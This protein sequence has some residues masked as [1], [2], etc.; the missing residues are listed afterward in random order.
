LETYEW[1]T[2]SEVYLQTSGL[3]FTKSAKE[4]IIG[5]IYQNYVSP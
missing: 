1:K 4:P 3:A 5:T 2:T